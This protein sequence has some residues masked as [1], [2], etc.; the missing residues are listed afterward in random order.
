MKTFDYAAAWREIAR[1]AYEAL[2]PSVHALLAR[3]AN[4]A[5]GCA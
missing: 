1:P 5:R 2:P 3:V 4:E